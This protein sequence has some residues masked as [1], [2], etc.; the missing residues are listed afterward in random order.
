MD[1]DRKSTVSSFYGA[2]KSLDAL[3]PDFVGNSPRPRD[4]ASSFFRGDNRMS[5]DLPNTRAPNAGYNRSSFFDV[6]R[7]EPVKGGRDEEA[8]RSNGAWDV[9]A[10]FNNAGPRYGAAFGQNSQGYQQLLPST[11]KAEEY[12][13]PVEMVT[14]PA[15]GSEW[16]KDELRDMTKS[17]RKEKKAESRREAWKAWNRGERGMCGRHC[18]RKVF[19]FAMFILCVLVAVALAITIPRVPGFA[20]SNESPLTNATGSWKSTIPTGFSRFPANFSFPA[21]AALQVD[22]GG[23][24]VPLTFTHLRANIYDLQTNMK[25]ATGDLGKKTFQPKALTDILLPLNFTY[26]AI[27]DSDQ[28]WVNWYNACKNSGTY[29]NGS[30]PPAQFRI[31]LTMN[32]FGLPSTSSTSAEVSN[33]ACPIELPVNSA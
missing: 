24:F 25:V 33:A 20:F 32:I 27:N 4:D 16:S 28:T 6:G 17:G 15:L 31:L 3:N 30:R 26:V 22:T 21:Y 7:E 1:Y 12:S 2:R 5:S 19:V 18:T 9:Y 23:N 11:S 14:V 13:G 29:S 10:D 8:D